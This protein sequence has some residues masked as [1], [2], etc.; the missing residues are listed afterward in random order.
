MADRGFLLLTSLLAAAL[1]VDWLISSRYSGYTAA[2]FLAGLVI[3]LFE[4]GHRLG[5]AFGASGTARRFE[6]RLSRRAAGIAASAIILGLVLGR[7]AAGAPPGGPDHG[8]AILA[9]FPYEG[10]FDPTRPA[11]DVIL[12]LVDFSRLSRLAVED[13]APPFAS[14]RALSAVHRVKR[15]NG[16]NIV[17]E[18]EFELMA[19][20]EGPFAWRIP[21]SSAR[22]IE[23]TLDRDRV[24]ILIEPGGVTGTV[25]ISR[26]GSHQ[27]VIRRAARVRSEAGVETLSL[28]VNAVPS[29]RLIVEPENE[30]KR[31]GETNARGR[32]DLQADGSL[33][34]RLG[35]VLS[36]EVRWPVPD[37]P[38]SG[39]PSGTVEGLILWDITPAGDRV[40]ARFT[41]HQPQELSTI[42]LR[43]PGRLDP[44]VRAGQR[45][46]SVSSARKTPR[47]GNG[48]CM[49]ILRCNAARRS[50]STA[51]CRSTNDEGM[52]A[53]S[54]QRDVRARL[55]RCA[56]YLVLDPSEW[57][58][59]PDRWVFAVR[60]TGPGRFDPLPDTDP[61]SDESFVESWGS[62]PRGTVDALRDQP[63]R[64]RLL[65]RRCR[66]ARSDESS[67]QADD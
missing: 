62:S 51:G 38:A 28:P 48:P 32:M 55:P 13:V 36:L 10:S 67:G 8:S 57:S 17:V 54:P 66:P 21:V 52:A 16:P 44:A 41:F 42:R 2:V 4:L 30:G 40:R 46:W 7:L 19:S 45:T 5:R 47:K 25:A 18:S 61:I 43:A 37:S 49:S 27:L 22:D 1:L 64:P 9:L 11:K 65:A 50:S 39:R 20:G 29:A 6:S 58:G 35:P 12:S 26:A 23:A 31:A 15:E 53:A 24:S 33:A 60:E 59:I 3:L 34:G 56:G 14:V 63:V